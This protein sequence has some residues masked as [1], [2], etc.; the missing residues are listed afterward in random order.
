MVYNT[1]MKILQLV[2]ISEKF[3]SLKAIPVWFKSLGHWSSQLKNIREALGM[4]QKQ[5][6]KR[7]NTTQQN[8]ARLE[9]NEVSPS[10]DTLSKVAK[11]LECELIIGLIPR[12][13][14]SKIVEERAKQIAKSINEQSV[15]NAAMEL[16]KP[17]VN[18]VKISINEFKENLIKNKRDLLW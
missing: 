16:Q 4:T 12:D 2:Q 6:A 18:L 5:L 3:K 10:I 1:N 14:L 7:A 15:A 13:N 11:A 17:N 9:K 8:I